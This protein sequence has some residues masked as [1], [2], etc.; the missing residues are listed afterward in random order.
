MLTLVP[1]RGRALV[2]TSQSDSL[3]QPGDTSVSV[4]EIEAFV[5]EAN[6]AFPALKLTPAD[7]ALVH[8]GV[9]PAEANRGGGPDLRADPAILD[10]SSA[11]AEGGITVIGVKYTTARL[12][13]ERAVDVVARRLGKRLTPSR[14]STTILPGAGIADHEALAIETARHL[15]FE[16]PLPAIRHLISLYAERSADIVRLL[17]ERPELAEPVASTTATLGAEV[18]FVVRHEMAVR[19]SDVVM[20][21]TTLGTAAHPGAEAVAACARIAAAELGW[22][23]SRIREE[24]AAVDRLY[25]VEEAAGAAADAHSTSV[26][27][28]RTPR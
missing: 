4:A 13:A 8:R 26:G 7:V 1:W 6:E 14:T 17:H 27:F 18:V 21:R 11:G 3:V 28:T 24:I 19:L 22:D 5:A 15:G 12:V 9:V 23:R 2:G 10:H 16:M 25:V 20:R